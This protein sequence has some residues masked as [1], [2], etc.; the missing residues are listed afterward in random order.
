MSG[1][2][3]PEPTRFDL[4]H[5]FIWGSLAAIAWIMAFAFLWTLRPLD[6]VP[7][8]ELTVL[9]PTHAG[10]DL[11]VRVDYCKR[12]GFAPSAV[13]WSLVDGV[14]IMLP[15]TIVTLAP[16]CRVLTL[17]LPGTPHMTPGRYRLRVDGVYMLYPWRSAVIESASSPWFE[18]LP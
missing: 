2:L 7:R 18:V 8:L 16:G 13:R 17:V 6:P 9:G 3:M 14:T 4:V 10:S 15:P 5:N 12:E 11:Q 1:S